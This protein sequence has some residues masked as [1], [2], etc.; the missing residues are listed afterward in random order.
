[1]TK[2]RAPVTFE[3]ALAR[4]AG[5]IGWE[6]VGEVLGI[7]ERMARYYGEPDS[8][9]A[10]ERLL[11]SQVIALDV[12][13]QLGGGDGAPMYETYG[14]MLKARMAEQF[15]DKAALGILT[16]DVIR[17]GSEA[18]AALVRAQLPGATDQ[19]R[20]LAAGETEEAIAALTRTLPLLTKRTGADGT[21]VEGHA[22]GGA[23]L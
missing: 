7:K 1:M 5:Q 23:E 22:P 17:E 18:H 10:P 9:F 20:A 12:A 19:D 6:K 4:I 13:F 3:N 2:T 8:P 21:N 14:L 11:L 15:A 16:I